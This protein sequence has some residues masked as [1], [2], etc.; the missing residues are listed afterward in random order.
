[1]KSSIKESCS[2]SSV[3]DGC[4]LNNSEKYI[5]EEIYHPTILG[6]ISDKYQNVGEIFPVEII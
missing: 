5:L 2:F 6:V 4:S 1:M 3:A